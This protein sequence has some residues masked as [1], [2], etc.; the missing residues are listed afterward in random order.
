[1]FQTAFNIVEPTTLLV[2]SDGVLDSLGDGGTSGYLQLKMALERSI[3][4]EEVAQALRERL[5]Q[6]DLVDDATYAFLRLNPQSALAGTPANGPGKVSGPHRS[7]SV[8]SGVLERIR[9]R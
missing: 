6:V 8:L 9:G 2:C 4:P 1:M 7:W 5:L 3:D